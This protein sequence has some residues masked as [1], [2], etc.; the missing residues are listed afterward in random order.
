MFQ[1]PTSPMRRGALLLAAASYVGVGVGHFTHAEFFVGIMPPYLP[2]HLEL[3]W[4]SGLFEVLG[5]VG[6]LFA[7]TRRWASYMLIA[8]LIA[9]FPANLNMAMNP[10]PF[11]AE[12]MPLWGLY[13]RLPMQAVFIAW[14][15]WVGRPDEREGANA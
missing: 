11:V 3:V 9:V 14:A 7:R 8:L 5:G 1:L 6:L 13:A 2:M 4:L 10:A 12:G 15:Y